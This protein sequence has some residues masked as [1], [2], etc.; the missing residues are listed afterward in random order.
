MKLRKV[1]SLRVTTLLDNTVNSLGPL[2]HWGL[3]TLL[4]Y[5][6]SDGAPR[7]VLLDTGSDPYCLAQNAKSLK[8]DLSGLGAV[9]LSHGH[10]DHTA[11][12]V[13]VTKLNPGIAIHAHPSTFAERNFLSDKGERRRQSPPKGEG[14]AELKEAGARLV[15]GTSPRE[16]TPGI[17]ATG[18]VPRMSFETIMELSGGR[19]LR[20][21]AGREVDDLIPDDQSVFLSLNGFGLVVVTGCA[22]SG[23]LNTLSYIEELTGEK[24][25]AL[26]G[27]THLTQRKPDYIAKTIEDLKS[28]DLALLS[29]S[30]CTGFYATAQ[31]AAVFP[32]SF[33]LN[34]S[35]RTFDFDELNKKKRLLQR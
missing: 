32:R 29:P 23:A 19:V 2:A 12:T 35:G 26:I 16:V 1:S 4:T 25:R 24:P 5:V 33:E 11:A 7:R 34:Y 15:Y 30:H 31:L 17:W 6:D 22:H 28:Y 3:S 14:L 9:I 21:K 18:E 27:G 10:L 20:E 13:E 8:I